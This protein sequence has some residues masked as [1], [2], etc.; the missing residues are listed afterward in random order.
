VTIT[1][2]RRVPT[3]ERLAWPL[4]GWLRRV[5]TPVAVLRL[6]IAGNATY[7]GG[8]HLAFI[9][10]IDR[11]PKWGELL[12]VSLSHAH[13]DPYWDEIKAARELFFDNEMDVMMV[14]PR[15]AD[16]VN[17]HE[18]AFHLIEMPEPWGLR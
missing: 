9:V 17:L 13:R 4:G 8:S 2:R 11:T 3:A 7:Q 10:T 14:L 15:A 18:H 5:K 16:Y 1:E 6:N 12:H